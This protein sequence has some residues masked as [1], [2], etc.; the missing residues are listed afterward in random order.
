M[1]TDNEGVQISV[2]SDDDYH[3]TQFEKPPITKFVC[4]G[5]PESKNSSSAKN[6]PKAMLQ[7]FVDYVEGAISDEAIDDLQSLIENE[8]VPCYN[9]CDIGHEVSSKKSK[10]KTICALCKGTGLLSNKVEWLALVSVIESRLK[11]YVVD[12]L[13]VYEKCVGADSKSGIK[14]F[15]SQGDQLNLPSSRKNSNVSE[16]NKSTHSGIDKFRPESKCGSNLCLSKTPYSIEMLS[17]NSDSFCF[18]L[19]PKE[20]TASAHLNRLALK[21][22]RNLSPDKSIG[23]ISIFKSSPATL[24]DNTGDYR[25]Q[26]LPFLL[27]TY[28]ACLIKKNQIEVKLFVENN[29]SEDWPN[30]VKIIGKPGCKLTHEVCHP[31][32]SRLR[33]FSRIGVKFCFDINEQDLNKEASNDLKFQFVAFNHPERVKFSSDFIIPL[34]CDK[35]KS[36]LLFCKFIQ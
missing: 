2:E 19:D 6:V 24:F 23:K 36:K 25:D 33:A 5:R 21:H 32:S 27:P 15:S 4:I 28:D 14:T 1:Y 7:R 34:Q 29:T 22:N 18:Q 3:V 35:K 11:K 26:S 13:K 10:R 20:N 16:L 31:I 30:D 8:D 17:K 9:C 12:P